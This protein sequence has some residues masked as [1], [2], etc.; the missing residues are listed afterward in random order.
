MKSTV[1][2]LLGKLQQKNL[3]ALRAVLSPVFGAGLSPVTGVWGLEVCAPCTCVDIPH[4]A[5]SGGHSL[6]YPHVP[7]VSP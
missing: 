5:V 6:E 7:I 1:E 2:Q 3:P 4:I